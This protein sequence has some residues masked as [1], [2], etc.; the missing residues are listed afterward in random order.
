MYFS[1]SQFWGRRGQEEEEG[2]KAIERQRNM[3]TVLIVSWQFSAPDGSEKRKNVQG[4][5]VG[6]KRGRQLHLSAGR[7]VGAVS[8]MIVRQKMNSERSQIIK[9]T[10]KYLSMSI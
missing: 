5:T 2:E 6:G 8:K 1:G 9:L 3:V 10:L 4:D 7:A